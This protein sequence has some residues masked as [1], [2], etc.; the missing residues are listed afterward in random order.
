MAKKT[1]TQMVSD[2][3][4]KMQLKPTVFEQ[5]YQNDPPRDPPGI[6]VKSAY[7]PRAPNDWSGLTLDYANV[8]FRMA[9]L[10]QERYDAWNRAFATW[11][12]DRA[13]EYHKLRPP[14]FSKHDLHEPHGLDI[15]ADYWDEH[16]NPEKAEILRRGD[17]E[18]VRLGT[19]V[20]QR[21]LILDSVQVPAEAFEKEPNMRLRS[22]FD[23]AAMPIVK[24]PN[25]LIR[26]TDT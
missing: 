6:E 16:G 23:A 24:S 19:H 18:L 22:W 13:I 26:N 15:A 11:L 20:S 7:P 10:A 3:I 9:Q 21:S 17:V 5:E 4:R 25:F 14:E 2:H 8:E 12:M 1:V